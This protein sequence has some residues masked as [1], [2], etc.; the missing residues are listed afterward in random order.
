MDLLGRDLLHVP[1]RLAHADDLKRQLET[2]KNRRAGDEDA[3]EELAIALALAVWRAT[4]GAP[5]PG[6]FLP[7]APRP[8]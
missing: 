5:S 1:R 6:G 4:R 7:R 2:M 3:P 8:R